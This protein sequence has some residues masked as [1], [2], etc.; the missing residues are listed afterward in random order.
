MYMKNSI[1]PF[2]LLTVFAC[3]K[4]K[5]ETD[6]SK[7]M[8]VDD[9][10]NL[11]DKADGDGDLEHKDD[12][13]ESSSDRSPTPEEPEGY[14]YTAKLIPAGTFTMG[15]TSEQDSYCDEST[16]LAHEVTIS[17]DFYMMESEVAQQ[18][19]QRVMGSNPSSFQGLNRP[20]EKVSWFDAVKFANTLSSIEGLEKCYSVD[21]NTVSWLNLSC[22]GWRLPTDAEWEYAARGGESHEYAG[23]DSVD[24]VAWYVENSNNQ[25]HDVCGKQ[26]N[27]YGLCDM[28]GN[29]WEWVWDYYGEYSRDSVVNPTGIS[30]AS[31]RVVRGGCWSSDAYYLRFA[32]RNYNAPTYRTVR[33]GFRLSRISP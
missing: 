21:G 3:G 27:G 19:Y 23:S 13:N 2:I 1:V 6:L 9:S 15:C 32:L 5:K 29:V 10:M 18:L 8:S 28:S 4:A 7:G 16:S 14:D 11:S 30:S 22:T 25:T 17:Q 33:I 24:E 26:A 20:V 12:G 31:F